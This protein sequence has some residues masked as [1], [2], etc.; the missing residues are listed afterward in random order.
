MFTWSAVYLREE[1]WLLSRRAVGYRPRQSRL[2]RKPQIISTFGNSKSKGGV[3]H[4]SKI[5]EKIK[6]C[7]LSVVEFS[8]AQ[9]CLNH[10]RPVERGERYKVERVSVEKDFMPYEVYIKMKMYVYTGRVKSRA[11]LILWNV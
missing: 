2:S 1:L 4:H 11:S 7:R 6:T 8:L 3:F 5:G 9:T 10:T